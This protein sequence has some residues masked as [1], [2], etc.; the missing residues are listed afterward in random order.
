[1]EQQFTHC[2]DRIFHHVPECVSFF[3]KAGDLIE[4]SPYDLRMGSKLRGIHGMAW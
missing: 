3:T 4:N 2:I 1:M